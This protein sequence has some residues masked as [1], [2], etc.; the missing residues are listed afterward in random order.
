MKNKVSKLKIMKRSILFILALTLTNCQIEESPAIQTSK[1]QTI[2]NEEATLFLGQA[3]NSSSRL[4]Q[5]GV[6]KPELGK[7][8]KEKINNSDQL[9]T[10]I[11]LTANDKNQNS[12][13]LMLKVGGEI[14]SVVFTMSPEKNIL[15]SEFSGK[16][17]IYELNGNFVNGFRVDNGDIITQFIKSP[18]NK[19]TNRISGEEEEGVDLKEVIVYNRY[20][21]S[22]SYSLELAFFSWDFGGGGGGSDDPDLSFTWDSGGS[23]G[24]GGTS[25]EQAIEDNID[26]TLL[27]P[28]PKGVMEQ[29]K[30]TT[31]TDIANILAK[32]GANSI[33]TVNMVMKPAGTYAETQRISKY[34]YEIRVDRDRYTDGTKL[35]KA[36]ALIHEIIYAYFLSIVDDYNNN[37][38]TALPSFPELFEAYVLKEYPNSTDKQDAQHKVM[39]D[40]YVDAMAS[41]LQEYDANYLIDYQVYKDLAWG[42]L[43]DAPI[44]DK[45][46]PPA[47]T[48]GNRIKN[49][50]GCESIG[51][52]VEL[53][54]PNEQKPVGKPCN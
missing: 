49:R 13:I 9:L 2:S 48:E 23:G 14:K 37:P 3:L 46:F 35:F 24:G 45:T 26:D 41:A 42:G 50:Y 52:A 29:L 16:I 15:K 39:A 54:T 19:T 4:S 30:N 43:K 18:K 1:I 25:T 28:C 17:L 53:G 21:Y 34:N 40:R 31:N 36:T 22:K 38:S 47:S 51:R 8:T 27:D 11:P 10:V 44:F 33:Y 12:R 6:V 7:I 20:R 5:K 32:L